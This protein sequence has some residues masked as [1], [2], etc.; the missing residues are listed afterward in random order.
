MNRHLTSLLSLLVFFGFASVVQADNLDDE[1]DSL[2]PKLVAPKPS[3]TNWM[4]QSRADA[5]ERALA[6]MP[7]TQLIDSVAIHAAADKPAA[8]WHG[9]LEI[10]AFVPLFGSG[11]ASTSGGSSSNSSAQRDVAQ[12]NGGSAV[13]N[14]DVHSA[15]A[16]PFRFHLR[17]GAWGINVE[18]MYADLDLRGNLAGPLGTPAELDTTFSFLDIAAT[19]TPL[20][21]EPGKQPWMIQVFAGARFVNLSQEVKIGNLP[22]VKDSESEVV[23]LLGGYFGYSFTEAWS[24]LLRVDFGISSN[25]T[26]NVQLGAVWRFGE[27]RH[28]SLGFGWRLTGIDYDQLDLTMNGPYFALGWI[29]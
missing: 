23:P 2:V 22:S 17:R 26:Y 18:F 14:I 24:A 7:A 19:W 3:T 5:Q 20:L 11:S 15:W 12:V 13:D 10:Y 29:F 9:L 28:W 25:L 1:I 4:A 8:K 27:T 16:I 21:P 6:K